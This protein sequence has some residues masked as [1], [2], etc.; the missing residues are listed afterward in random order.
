MKDTEL[1][2]RLHD[3]ATRGAALDAEEQKQLDA[4]YAEQDATEQ[5]TLA[6]AA[7]GGEAASLREQVD[8]TLG[9]LE[10]AAQRVRQ[11]AAAN[12]ALRREVASLQRQV[13]E[14]LVPQA[15]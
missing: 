6:R 4:W 13:A 12:E 14:K 11:T 2:Q 5:G 8:R 1:G 10:V 9:Q 3:Q 7:S 15:A